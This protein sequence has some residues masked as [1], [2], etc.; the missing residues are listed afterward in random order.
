MTREIR[1]IRCLI[2]LSCATFLSGCFP[3][4]YLPKLGYERLEIKLSPPDP[5]LSGPGGV[6]PIWATP[7]VTSPSG[8]NPCGT[9]CPPGNPL[10]P[11]DPFGWLKH[12]SMGTQ[13]VDPIGWVFGI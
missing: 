6:G 3:T 11:I 5:I 1:F 10:Q 12:G 7:E 13:E 2:L 9:C 8:C 4:V